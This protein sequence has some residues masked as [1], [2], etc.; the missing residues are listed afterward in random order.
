MVEPAPVHDP[1]TVLADCQS[2]AVE[3]EGI[4]SVLALEDLQG[5]AAAVTDERALVEG[6]GFAS[7]LWTYRRAL[8]PEAADDDASALLN[9]LTVLGYAHF[10][11]MGE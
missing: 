9:V 8:E 7:L 3:R 5:S 11:E 4:Q 6:A 2:R 10:A 1:H